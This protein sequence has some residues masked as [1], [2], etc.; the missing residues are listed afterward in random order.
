MFACRLDAR[1]S[2]NSYLA[3]KDSG[4]YSCSKLRPIASV[5]WGPVA[6][7]GLGSK[8]P[9]DGLVGWDHLSRGCDF[10]AV[11]WWLEN[12]YQGMESDGWVFGFEEPA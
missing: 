9:S 12:I 6:L 5:L 4:P 10:S 1:L 8:N 7:A 3:Q 11:R 2:G